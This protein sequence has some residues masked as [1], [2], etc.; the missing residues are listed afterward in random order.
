MITA[1]YP[2]YDFTIPSTGQ[3]I[4]IRPF[5]VKEEK[6]LLMALQE[7]EP[8]DVINTTKQIIK[9]CIVEGDVDLEKMPFFDVDCL[10]IALRAKSVG[11]TIQVKFTCKNVVDDHVCDNVFPVEI[12]ISKC[13]LRRE[14]DIDPVIDLGSGMKVKMK[15]PSYSIMRTINENDN[16]LN[17]KIAIIVGS[18]D[19]VQDK[20]QVHTSKD[21]GPRELTAFVESMTQQTFKKLE[22]FVDN[23]PSF[24]IKKEAVCPEC[25]KT[26][27]IEWSEFT[28][29]FQ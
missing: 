8:V 12:D 5:L 26:H 15:Y 3:E 16:V 2:L 7:A 4:K 23:F 10:F 28:S 21:L 11:E 9:G 24:L 6:L 18:I 14:K 22:E 13:S 25:K 27:E 1:T 20:E 29:F 17:K 19:Y